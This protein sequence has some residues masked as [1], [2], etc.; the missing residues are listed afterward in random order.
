MS[1]PPPSETQASVTQLLSPLGQASSV[2]PSQSSS[3]PLQT[4]C[5]APGVPGTTAAPLLSAQ[6][7]AVPPALQINV[8]RVA[9]EPVPVAV[10]DAP[11]AKPSLFWP[12]Q[13]SSTALH[14]SVTG[15]LLQTQPLAP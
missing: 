4:S 10:H 8:P 7:V 5:L 3:S 13:L 14:F 9:Q 6:N 11:T 1:V 15:S 12:L 2:F